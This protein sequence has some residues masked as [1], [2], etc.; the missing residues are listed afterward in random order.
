MYRY[1]F[2]A[3]EG[4]EM[5]VFRVTES[6]GL[7][8]NE[9]VSKQVFSKS[10]YGTQIPMFITHSKDFKQDGTAPGYQY[11]YVSVLFL[12]K[13]KPNWKEGINQMELFFC[14]IRVD[15]PLVSMHS[16]LLI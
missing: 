3:P 4:K 11:G 13:T 12:N 8:P 5:S 6:S 2:H 7:N 1:N 10:K 9:F 16:F 15:S 14:F